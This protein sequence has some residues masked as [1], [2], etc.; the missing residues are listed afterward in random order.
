MLADWNGAS[1]KRAVIIATGSEIGL[2][3]GARTALAADGIAA[4][5]V[6]M[7]STTVFDRQDAS[8]RASVLPAGVPRVAVEAG[9]TAGWHKY[10]GAIDD[11]RGAIV[12]LDTYGESA[13]AA[14][15]VQAFQLHR[16]ERRR[17]GEAGRCEASGLR[18]IECLLIRRATARRRARHRARAV[19]S[20]RT[21]Y[22]GMIPDAYLDG[23]QVEAS[24]A[25]WD[26]VLTGRT[27]HHVRVR[28]GTWDGHRRFRR[29]QPIAAPKHGFDAE[30]TAIY[31]R[32]EFQRAGLGRGLVG[33]VAGAQ[34]ELGATGL[35]TWV[36]A[37]NKPARVFYE[38]LGGEL[39][40]EQPF[41]W[42][43]MDLMEAGYGWR[44][45]SALVAA[46]AVAPSELGT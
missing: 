12:G 23:M 9:S 11:G 7:P 8:W 34:R 16:G 30:L 1:P 19:D 40:V 28:R 39:V 32:R 5:V 6:S 20:W 15:A 22:R 35:L 46:C 33:A 36:I 43:G 25:L 17:H 3:M 45:L 13:P 10:V 4:R 24:T 41:Q 26:R 27:E 2:A 44:D 38:R 37:G 29:R 18:P 42:D 14:G 21:T 31:L